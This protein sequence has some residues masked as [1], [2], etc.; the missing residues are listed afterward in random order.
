MRFTV[1]PVLK[2][3]GLRN[4][5]VY[6]VPRMGDIIASDDISSG[7]FNI[8]PVYISD[9]IDLPEFASEDIVEEEYTMRDFQLER[10][11][12]FFRW[13]ADLAVEAAKN[14]AF[15]SSY[16]VQ[17]ADNDI[18]AICDAQSR[19]F[20]FSYANV[21][22]DGPKIGKFMSSTYMFTAPEFNRTRSNFVSV[23]IYAAHSFTSGKDF[24]IVE[25]ETT[26]VPK[27]FADKVIKTFNGTY[28][29]LYGFTRNVGTEVY[30]DSGDMSDVALTYAAPA[31]QKVT[32]N[33]T[34]ELPSW[35][36]MYERDTPWLIQMVDDKKFGVKKNGA[37][38][39]VNGMMRYYLRDKIW[40]VNGYTI[41]NLCHTDFDS[42]ARW[43]VDVNKP[44]KKST[45]GMTTW[46]LMK[47]QRSSFSTI[48]IS[49]G[50][51]AGIT[52]RITLT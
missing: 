20:D 16:Q 46:S 40:T 44:S 1:W 22:T 15:A 23:K 18:A 21:H 48:P 2:T 8:E 24:Y 17:A 51:S 32:G 25:S 4:L 9:D 35:L 7:D 33:Y 3:D 38:A 37:S 42:S 31:I 11:A 41:E 13:M 47:L 26:T 30:I 28:N 12:N 10:W 34:L 14:V 6:I 5:F 50:K 49:C 29:Y 52:G 43:Y 19:T 36:L 39:K 45:I 27:N